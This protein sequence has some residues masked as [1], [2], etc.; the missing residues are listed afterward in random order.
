MNNDEIIS[1]ETDRLIIRK[2]ELSDANQLYNSYGKDTSITKYMLWKNFE[3]VDAAKKAIEYYIKCYQENSSFVQY[4]IILKSN[5]KLIG[6]VCYDMNKRHRF[7]DISYIIAT[8][9]QKKGYMTEALNCLVDY[10]FN[11][12]RCNRISAE[13]MIENIASINLLKK[14]N[15]TQEGVEISKYLKKDGKYSDIV[16]MARVNG[17]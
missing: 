6:Q 9:Y 16:I 13:V 2:F 5:N 17:L 7:A 3:S 10:L 15:F 8:S 4:A 12:L 14:C 11:D 1:L